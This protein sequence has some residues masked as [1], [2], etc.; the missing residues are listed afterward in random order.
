MRN[1]W[2]QVQEQAI[3]RAKNK[4]L[5][6]Q[7]KNELKTKTKT[8]PKPN[9]YISDVA[10]SVLLYYIW[11]KVIFVAR[12]LEL[13]CRNL[14]V[15]LCFPSNPRSIRELSH[16]LLAKKHIGQ[17]LVLTR[18][19][20]WYQSWFVTN[21]TAIQNNAVYRQKTQPSPPSAK[22]QVKTQGQTGL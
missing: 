3:H 11:K 18:G 20:L 17:A 14:T 7:L 22:Q 9:S 13:V 16:T 6:Q 8:Q 5:A 19:T 1:V 12:A 2:K 10:A 4:S 21:T 15:S